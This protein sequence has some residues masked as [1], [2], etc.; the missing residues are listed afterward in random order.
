MKKIKKISAVLALLF[1]SVSAAASITVKGKSS[2]KDLYIDLADQKTYPVKILADYR[3]KGLSGVLDLGTYSAEEIA[4]FQPE[5]TDFFNHRFDGW[6]YKDIQRTDKPAACSCLIKPLKDGTVLFGRNMDL[7]VSFY[8]AY[9]FR[10]K[11]N[12]KDT[13]DTVNISYI[14]PNRETFDQIAETSSVAE[15]MY[16]A[17]PFLATDVMNSRG[18]VLEQNIRSHCHEAAC[19]GT[20]PSSKDRI[21]ESLL[22]RLIGDHC[23]TVE[24]ALEFVKKYNIYSSFSQATDWHC[25]IAMM[26][27]TGRYGVMEFVYNKAVWHEGRPGF[28]CGQTNFFWDK[29][30]NKASDLNMGIGRWQQLMEEYNYINSADDMERAMRNV[31]YSELITENTMARDWHTDLLTEWTSPSLSSIQNI[32]I[33]PIL[34]WAEKYKFTVD[35]EELTRIQKLADRQAA[36]NRIF[37]EEY[38]QSPEGRYDVITSNDFF[39][40]YFSMLPAEEKKLSGMME[41]SVISYVTDSKSLTY[42]IHFFETDDIYYAGLYDTKIVTAGR[43]WPLRFAGAFIVIAA[44]VIM[45]RKMRKERLI[46]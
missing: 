19:S 27:S 1:F 35:P 44:A 34:E 24:E 16:M 45:F 17:A 3:D 25:A 7:P 9:I 31:W 11:G 26:D 29:K 18:L 5:I 13:Y 37:T 33:N 30:A 14:T 12:G 21:C 22:L 2:L 38:V 42:K 32:F 43:N 39:V 41:S 6:T 10:T 23:A 4:A 15:R 20:N 36:E 46:F 40:K 8:P 28:A